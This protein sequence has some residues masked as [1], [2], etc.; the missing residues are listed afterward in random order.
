MNTTKTILLSILIFS[1]SSNICDAPGRCVNSSYLTD[2]FATNSFDCWMK[3]RSYQG[4]NFGTFTPDD[5]CSLFQTCIKLDTTICQNCRT[6]SIECIQCDFPGLCFVSN[7]YHHFFKVAKT[8][9][10]FMFFIS[11]VNPGG[12]F[13][14]WAN[15]R[16]S[17]LL[18]LV[19]IN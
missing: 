12:S 4:C 17:S 13:E 2:E 5:E 10:S 8:N 11:F 14:F 15:T 7:Y 3:C 16:Q 6:S 1:V 18:G 19:R 9:N